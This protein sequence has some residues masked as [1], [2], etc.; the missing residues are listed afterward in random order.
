MSY[1]F[2]AATV[3]KM[4]ERDVTACCSANDTIVKV[5]E[6]GS[7]HTYARGKEHAHIRTRQGARTHTHAH[8]RTLH[9]HR[10]IGVTQAGTQ[11]ERSL[12]FASFSSHIHSLSLAYPI[13]VSGR[14]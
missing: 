9:T 12:R 7:T 14:H 13:S 3:P 5:R 8:A 4:G 10:A 6:V 1:L 2:V 11:A